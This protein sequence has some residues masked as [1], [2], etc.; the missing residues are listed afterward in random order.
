VDGGH[1]V[2][3]CG[4]CGGLHPRPVSSTSA[5]KTFQLFFDRPT[6]SVRTPNIT[7]RGTG[8][9][10]NWGLD[11]GLFH[12]IWV[13]W[14]GTTAKAYYDDALGQTTLGVGTAA[15]ESQN[16]SL[17]AR[18]VGAPGSQVTGDIDFVAFTDFAANPPLITKWHQDLYAPWRP[19]RRPVG[20]SIISGS[21][22]GTDIQV[23]YAPRQALT[24]DRVELWSDV[25]SNGGEFIGVVRNYFS[26]SEQANLSGEH[27]V[28]LS[29]PLSHPIR[30]LVGTPTDT[31]NL[32]VNQVLRL[33]KTD[34]TWSEH[35]IS[36]TTRQNQRGE[37]RLSITARSIFQDL[38]L[39]GDRHPRHR[40]WVGD[41]NVRGAVAGTG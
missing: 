32:R 7:L 30:Y 34:G 26:L 20:K 21:I 2:P 24:V 41:H 17:A 29:V 8:T 39:P 13:T 36:E 16:I 38:G 19:Y 40:R 5:N 35:R 1:A 9:D 25:K 33:V 18:T 4:Q 37:R 28:T 27:T 31:P 22:P 14:D 3:G 11:D 15:E 6:T 12:T 10:L 23:V